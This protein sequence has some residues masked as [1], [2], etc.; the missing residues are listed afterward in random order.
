MNSQRLVVAIALGLILVS[1]LMVGL[2]QV[3]D[4]QAQVHSIPQ[5]T[6][7]PIFP[8]DDSNPGVAADT[9]RAALRSSGVVTAVNRHLERDGAPFEARGMNYYPKDYAWDRFW[10]SYTAATTQID[11]ELDLAR[12]LGVNAVR[13]FVPY[14]RFDGADQTHLD[15][16]K[17]L[18]ARL[19]AHDMVAIVTL[20]DLYTGVTNTHPYSET[21][22]VTNTRHISAVVNTLGAANPTVLAWDIK[23]EPDRD[24]TVYG[25]DEV[26]NWLRE[27]ISYTRGLDP[28]HLVTIGFYGAV[29]GTP[30]YTDTPGLVYSPTI[31]AELSQTVDFV[32]LHYFLPEHCFAS[33]LQALQSQIGEKPIVLEEYG[34]H[35][36][37]SGA[38][39]HT[40]TEQAAYFNALPSLG[41]AHGI[42]GYLFWTLSD[43]SYILTNT[44]ETHHCQGIL[45]NSL[46][47]TCQVT[48]TLDYTEKPAAETIRRHYADYITYLD[49]LDSWVDPKTD[50]PPPGWDDNWD[51][52]GALLRGYSLSNTLWSHDVGKVAFSKRVSGTVSNT[53][54]ALSP[55]LLDVDV[56]R[57]P[58]LAGQVYSYS[59][60]DSTYGSDSILYVGAQA[61][62]QITRLL[63]I[64]PGASL[65][66]TFAVDLRQPPLNW[67]GNH[68]FHIAFELVP[69]IGDDGYSASYEFDWIALERAVTADFVAVPTRGAFPLTIVFTNTSSGDYTTSLW[70]FGDAFTSAQHSPTHTYTTVGAY[71]VTLTVSGLGG[72]DTLTRANHIVVTEPPPVAGFIAQPTYG[73]AP[74]T[75]TFTNT[76]TGVG[77]GWLWDFGDAFTSTEQH[78]AHTYASTG[79]YTVTL[80]ASGPGGSDTLTRMNYISA[81]EPVR[82]DFDANP[83]ADIV[84]LTVYF[85]DTSTGP[86]ALWHWG[87]GHGGTSDQ[88]HPTH[89]YTTT[90][91]YT[92]TLTA[93]AAGGSALLPG[94]TDTITRTRY[95][96]VAEPPPQVDFV[97]A[98]RSGN[99]P[100][101]VQFT[102]TVTGTVTAYAWAFGDGGT[103]F[104]P[105]PTHTYQ[106]AGSFGVTL[107][108]TGPGG[109]D[110][111]SQPGYITVNASP[112][113]P[114]ATFSADVVSGTAPLKVTFTAITSGTVEQRHWDFGDGDA[115]FTGPVVS[116]TYVTAGTF[117]VSLTVSN[118]H[119]GF[120]VSKPCYITVSEGF[121]IYLPVVL[122]NFQ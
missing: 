68:T 10:I 51:E 80:T 50:E 30:C 77:T 7:A 59:V 44:E 63:T 3:Q 75:V 41:E 108:V 22:Y 39:P 101:T 58:I 72:T 118:T 120:T 74:L 62:A 13:I 11:A 86:V 116:H 83:K 96:T 111:A 115:A 82:A 42:A 37:D 32:S 55:M 23:N 76:T 28:H 73:F 114:T 57:Y 99:P 5:L 85:T 47:D 90:G 92:V 104:T 45:R 121:K 71:T 69:V 94:G 122:R 65:P 78:P 1:L 19:Q 109:T 49:Q 98:P 20:F 4:V 81:F 97:G 21:D 103:A 46:A 56:S 64:T 107:V 38:N 43:F 61:D 40:E 53:G 79:V 35:T 67:T 100:L 89:T 84:P 34:L 31:A 93:Q 119:G 60:R 18:M 33:D 16:L 70:D 106:S 25:N 12:D 105:N 8:F 9:N 66:Y 113:A 26:K 52:I 27:M 14:D 24:Y 15:H 88:Q 54:V 17:D 36:M 112:G 2:R 95:I 87:F 117:D 110:S 91:E 6:P 102:S 29:T 48:T